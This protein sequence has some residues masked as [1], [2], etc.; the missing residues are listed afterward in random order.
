MPGLISIARRPAG[1]APPGPLP[2]GARGQPDLGPAE[3]ETLSY[4]CGEWRLFQKRRGHRWSLDDLVTAWVAAPLGEGAGQGLDLGCGQGS[5]LLL[6]AWRLPG[7]RFTGLEAQAERAALA[8]RSIR[9][10]GVEARCEVVDADLRDPG[11]L[12]P[13]FLAPL[14]TGTPPYFPRGTG[15]ESELPHARP[16]RFEVRGGLEAYLEAAARW[17]APGGSAVLCSAALERTRV[18]PAA[19]AV[20]LTRRNRLEVVPREGKAP[21]VLVDTFSAA[22]GPSREARITVRDRD[23]QW[24]PE[25]LAVR[26]AF[27]MPPRP[28]SGATLRPNR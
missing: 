17:L 15:T 13:G 23:G 1:W 26:A 6:L 3:D 27:G 20:G 2:P 19:A 11:A 4:L 5:V 8:R 16:C 21:L 28:G 7:V 22:K 24:T 25:F 9:Y 12:G 14:I 10:D 18:D